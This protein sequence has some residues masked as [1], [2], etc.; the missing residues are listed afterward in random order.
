ME[1]YP[2]NSNESA[3]DPAETKPEETKMIVSKPA[4]QRKR[5]LMHRFRA[6][7]VQGDAKTAWGYVLWDVLTPGLKSIAADALTQ[8]IERSIFGE[9]RS[10]SRYASRTYGNSHTSYGRMF[11][12]QRPDPREMGPVARRGRGFRDVGEIVLATR[13]EAEAVMDSLFQTIAEYKSVSVKELFGM[14]GIPA[15]F[16]DSDWG[17]T[18]LEGSDIR[19][20]SDGYVLDLPPTHPL[21]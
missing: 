11:Q 15:N 12:Q 1:E 14:V 5:S 9:A 10:S 13:G 7:F 19:R 20:V 6:T 17:W 2:S 18:S 21:N 4:S 8:G 16:T 3:D